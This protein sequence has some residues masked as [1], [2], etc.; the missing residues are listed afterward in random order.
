MKI[1]M[2]YLIKVIASAIIVLSV[3]WLGTFEMSAFK[4]IFLPQQQSLVVGE[5]MEQQLKSFSPVELKKGIEQYITVVK[6]HKEQCTGKREAEGVNALLEASLQGAHSFLDLME[7]HSPEG[8]SYDA[9]SLPVEFSELKESAGQ[10]IASIPRLENSVRLYSNAPNS[11]SVAVYFT[12]YSLV[13]AETALCKRFKNS[14][15][16][17]WNDLASGLLER[18]EGKGNVFIRGNSLCMT[19]LIPEQ[20]GKGSFLALIKMDTT[21]NMGE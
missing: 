17:V 18:P 21:G 20:A 1:I 11:V 5:T 19:N 6:Q 8:A 16:T 12:P 14:G 13:E 15:W 2:I 3:G 7:T 4:A 9:I 10:D